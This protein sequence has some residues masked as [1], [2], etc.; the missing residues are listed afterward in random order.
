MDPLRAL[1][2]NEPCWCGSDLKYKRCHGYF[3]PP[4]PGAPLTGYNDGGNIEIAP[5]TFLDPDGISV[6]K[7]GAPVVNQSERPV[8]PAW[9]VEENAL[10]LVRELSEATEPL[11]LEALGAERAQLL[12]DYGLED[13]HL[14]NPQVASFSESAVREILDQSRRLAAETLLSISAISGSPE[15]ANMLW[16]GDRVGSRLIGQ[17]LL[18][19][20]HYLM[21]DEL[22]DL[23]LRDGTVD[24]EQLTKALTRQSEL[25]PLI[26]L[27]TVVPALRDAAY[28]LAEVDAHAATQRD[29][30]N[31]ALVVWI[32]RQIRINGPSAKEVIFA[33]MVDDDQIDHPYMYGRIQSYDDETGGF[34]QRMLNDYDPGHNYGPWIE[35][36]KNQFTASRIHQINIETSVAGLFG[37]TYLTPSPFEGRLMRLKASR[38]APPSA[39][40]FLDVP[41]LPGAPVAELARMAKQE[42]IVDELRRA[43]SKATRRIEAVDLA[44]Q[45]VELDDLIEDLTHGT[46]RLNWRIRRD[47]FVLGGATVC[48][49]GLLALGSAASLP[50]VGLTLAITSAPY[51]VARREDRRHPS[52]AFWRARRSTPQ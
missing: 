4:P 40:P 23:A 26:R 11:G 39:L 52:Y 31:D 27:G 30:A 17:S 37:G 35:T 41:W 8:N 32:R 49:L 3:A 19:A 29:L 13:P 1:G 2:R 7:G 21:E 14:V 45:A 15:R 22:A 28:V 25:L 24:R 10:R 20:T 42:A 43:V 33:S 46:E 36:V 16:L 9:P 50:A 34:E 48:E 5:G 51:L 6:P 18:W 12:E 38:F 47:G 44:A